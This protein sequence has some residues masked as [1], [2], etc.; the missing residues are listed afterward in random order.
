MRMQM[1][2]RR[3]DKSERLQRFTLYICREVLTA[4]QS[5]ATTIQE[6]KLR[7]K[8][9]PEKVQFDGLNAGGLLLVVVLIAADAVAIADVAVGDSCSSGGLGSGAGVGIAGDGTA[10]AIG[11][12]TGTMAH[13]SAGVLS[14]MRRAKLRLVPRAAGDVRSGDRGTFPSP[15]ALEPVRIVSIVTDNCRPT[16]SD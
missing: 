7:L 14:L 6:E 5:R 2:K 4:E 10:G 13:E 9:Q 11:G 3:S 12:V 1:L 16:S 8:V 15:V